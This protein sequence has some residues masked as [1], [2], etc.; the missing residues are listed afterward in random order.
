MTVMSET[1]T[2]ALNEQQRL[3]TVNI[4]VTYIRVSPWISISLI[5]EPKQNI[6]D[7][8]IPKTLKIAFSGKNLVKKNLIHH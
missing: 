7:F 8:F 3:Y 2:A 4:S 1:G 5:N 6:L